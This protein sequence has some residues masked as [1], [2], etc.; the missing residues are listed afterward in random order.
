MNKYGERR[1]KLLCQFQDEFPSGMDDI[2]WEMF[3][4]ERIALLEA[5]LRSIKAAMPG[6]DDAADRVQRIVSEALQDGKPN[7]R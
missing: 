1:A 2:G 5:A 6:T 3:L 4:I 7:E